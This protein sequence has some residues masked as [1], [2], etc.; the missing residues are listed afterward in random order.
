MPVRIRG[1]IP[2]TAAQL[3]FTEWS[4]QAR[5]GGA[6]DCQRPPAPARIGVRSGRIEKLHSMAKRRETPFAF[7]H[8]AMN[9]L[10]TSPF[11]RASWSKKALTSEFPAF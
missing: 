5:V 3:A 11:L 1:L 9:G 8:A 7:I 2:D 10:N 4:K 6:Q